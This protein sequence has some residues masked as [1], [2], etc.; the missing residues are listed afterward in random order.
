MTKT[1][2]KIA[3]KLVST[4]PK[5]GSDAIKVNS[6]LVLKFDEPVKFGLTGNITI[7]D[8]KDIHKIA[9]TDP[10]IKISGK[11]IT[12]NPTTDLNSNSHYSVIIESSAIKDLAGNK[13]AGILNTT[14]LSFNTVDN[15]APQLD[16]ITAKNLSAPIAIDKNLVLTFNE[17]IKAGAGIIVLSNGNDTRKIAIADKSQIT[18]NGKTPIFHRARIE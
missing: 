16:A 9:I 11:T 8:S 7:S 3:P 17:A 13:F 1:T 4:T 12:I 2:D 18:I 14:T 6:N 10:Q 15:I 5:S